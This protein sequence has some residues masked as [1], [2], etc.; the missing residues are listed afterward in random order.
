VPKREQ[1]W[2]HWAHMQ[3]THLNVHPQYALATDVEADLADHV[4]AADP[5]TGYRLESALITQSDINSAYRLVPTDSLKLISSVTR[6]TNFT[7]NQTTLGASAE[8]FSSDLSFTSVGGD[9]RVE[10]TCS[11]LDS[12]GAAG[13]I[14]VLSLCD[15]SGTLISL[16]AWC[17]SGNGTQGGV[18]TAH[19]QLIRAFGAGST[20]LNVRGLYVTAGNGTAYAGSGYPD[21]RLAVYGPDL[22]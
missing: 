6:S 1:E 14:V 16:L 20:S 19:A 9:Y 5:H 4:A 21:M 22:T 15:G 8:V 10:F 7:I 13:S 2:A 17:G 12:G 3:D 18:C 11:R